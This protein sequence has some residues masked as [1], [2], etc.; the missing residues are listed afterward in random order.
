MNYNDRTRRTRQASLVSSASAATPERVAVPP[1]CAS[2][3]RVTE[4]DTGTLGIAGNPFALNFTNN[5][6]VLQRGGYAQAFA[7]NYL[8]S[9]R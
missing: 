2:V 1:L 7:P 8:I 3:C 9:R 5:G 6:G 4:P